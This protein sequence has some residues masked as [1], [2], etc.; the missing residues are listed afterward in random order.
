MKIL[1]S[2]NMNTEGVRR[3]FGLFVGLF[4]FAFSVA[5]PFVAMTTSQLHHFPRYTKG[6]L[7]YQ[8]MSRPNGVKTASDNMRSAALDYKVWRYGNED[9][10]LDRE[11]IAAGL[12]PI[13]YQPV[14][15]SSPAVIVGTPLAIGFVLFLAAGFVGGYA[16]AKH[17]TEDYKVIEGI[18]LLERADARKAVE[19]FKEPLGIGI[20]M[21]NPLTPAEKK[22]GR[23][24]GKV[25]PLLRRHETH[26]IVV[27]GAMGTGKTL[28]IR[29]FLAQLEDRN[30]LREHLLKQEDADA[31]E[32][33]EEDDEATA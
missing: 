4:L 12:I 7:A 32:T 25:L 22:L 21:N 20:I 24:R 15:S 17:K 30:K 2:R 9:H 18:R 3:R 5:V 27:V 11:F 28:L 33:T 8:L 23:F 6:Y 1:D 13:A 14:Y 31:V 26:G 29:Q 16:E 10:R 19:D